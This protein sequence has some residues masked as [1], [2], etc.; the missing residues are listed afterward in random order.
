MTK[1]QELV[2]VSGASSG[3]GMAT[4][5]ELAR[6]GFHVLA[7]VRDEAAAARLRR[8]NLEPVRLDVTDP[9]DVAGLAERV[10]AD[11]GSR[12]L[13]AVVNCAGMAANGPTELLPL[14][15]WRRMFEVN[16]F[17]QIALIQA[18]LP[19]LRRGSGRVVN[20]SSTGGRI[21]MPAFGAYS[22]TKFAVE[23]MSDALRREVAEQGVDVVVIQP[24]SVRTG[25]AE[26]G[27]R[28]AEVLRDGMS[29]GDRARYD[30]LMGT[31]FATI[32][33]FERTGLDAARAGAAIADSV[34]ARR[35]RPRVTIGRDAAIFTRLARVLPDRALDRMLAASGRRLSRRSR[36]TASAAAR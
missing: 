1:S 28:A 7:G 30:D 13:R 25:M 33:D 5:I 10:G 2:V 11:P 18:L 15:T 3:M 23:A 21:A 20:V 8:E 24:G 9:D 35:P 19:A 32:E 4:A 22:A 34:T 29:P 14:S 36:A 6:R 16:L 27:T 26:S 12:V 17:G 31:F